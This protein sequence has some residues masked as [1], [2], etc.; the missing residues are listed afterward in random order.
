MN[1]L[2][3]FYLSILATLRDLQTRRMEKEKSLP[4]RFDVHEK[5]AETWKARRLAKKSEKLR[6]KIEKG[7]YKGLN[8]AICEVNVLFKKVMKEWQKNNN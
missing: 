8:D 6:K 4:L 5:F 7:Y 2:E 1:D 3:N